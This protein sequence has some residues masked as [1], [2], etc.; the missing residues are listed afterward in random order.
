[1]WPF[2]HIVLWDVPT[3]IG[4]FSCSNMGC[5]ICNGAHDLYVK[6]IYLYS[7]CVDGNDCDEDDNEGVDDIQENVCNCKTHTHSTHNNP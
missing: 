5:Q 4:A 1:M 2:S 7:Y 6:Y 3:A